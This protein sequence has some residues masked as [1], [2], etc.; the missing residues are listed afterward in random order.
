MFSMNNLV[1]TLFLMTAFNNS[2]SLTK[3]IFDMLKVSLQ[4]VSIWPL[5]KTLGLE[6]V[7]I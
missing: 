3:K 7:D 1:I 5:S 6:H 2:W 4:Q